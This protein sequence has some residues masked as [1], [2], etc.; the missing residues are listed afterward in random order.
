MIAACALL[1]RLTMLRGLAT[2]ATLAATLPLQLSAQVRGPFDVEARARQLAHLD[3]DFRCP[4]PQPVVRDIR[5]EEY[6]ADKAY[7]VVDAKRRQEAD[8]AAVPLHRYARQ[9]TWL[10][11]RALLQRE[12]RDAVAGC[13]VRWLDEWAR[14]AGMLGAIDGPLAEHYRKW[15][16]AAIALAYA[17]IK[18]IATIDAKREARIDDWLRKL[19]GEMDRYYGKWRRESWNNHVYWQ[20]LAEV[21][22]AA[23]VDDRRLLE[24]GS[25]EVSTWRGRDHAPRAAAERGRAPG[26]GAR[27]SRLLA[28]AADPH[29]RDRRAQRVRTLRLPGRRHPP[30]GEGRSPAASPITAASR[31]WSASPRKRTRA[32]RAGASPGWN[33]TSRD[34]R[35]RASRNCSSRTGRSRTNGSA[36]T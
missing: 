7:T 2:L 10:A 8:R 22:V 5:I 35:I 21:A 9:V 11:D 30:A 33:P 14:H 25:R 32:A 29:R 6:Y 34:F 23:A 26:E 20:G 18:P 19:V 28:R 31:R 24:K 4:Q 17:G 36:A 1:P 16:L 13:L 15:T 3:A 27:L 12:H